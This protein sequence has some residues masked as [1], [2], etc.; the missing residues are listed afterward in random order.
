MRLI[1]TLRDRLLGLG[2]LFRDPE[3]ERTRKRQHRQ[4]NEVQALMSRQWRDAWNEQRRD[5]WRSGTE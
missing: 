4:I 2:H 5:A 1:D 3:Q